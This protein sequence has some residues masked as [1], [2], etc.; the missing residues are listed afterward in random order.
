VSL[1]VTSHAVVAG[2]TVVFTGVVR[3]RHHGFVEIQS[4]RDGRWHTVRIVGIASS[5]DYSIKVRAH[6][7]LDKVRAVA[8]SSSGYKRAVSKTVTVAAAPTACQRRSGH[9]TKLAGC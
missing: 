3:P 2:Q 4:H 8:L 6:A 1:H 7:G 5:G 9:V